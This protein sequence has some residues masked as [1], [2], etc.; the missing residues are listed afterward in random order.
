MAVAVDSNPC[1]VAGVFK[2]PRKIDT[3]CML[4]AMLPTRHAEQNSQIEDRA[5]WSVRMPLHG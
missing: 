4:A 1:C 5:E 2:N 3:S